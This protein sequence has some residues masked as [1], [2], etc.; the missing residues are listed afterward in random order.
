MISSTKKILVT[1]LLNPDLDGV[2]CALA[3]AEFLNKT[4]G[5][6]VAGIFGAPH[7][8]AQFVLDKFN[9]K[10]NH[11]TSLP[12]GYEDI[13]LVD[14]S[15]LEALPDLIKPERVIEIIDH[16]KTSQIEKFINAKI[17]IELVGAC[18]TLIAEKFKKNNLPISETAARL[19]YPAIFSNTDNFKGIVTKRDKNMVSWLDKQAN[20][21]PDFIHEMF[22]AKSKITKPIKDILIE[23]FKT[24]QFKNSRLGI[25]Q[26]EIINTDQYIK[27]NLPEIIKILPEIKKQKSLDYIFLNGLDLEGASNTFVAVDDIDI[28]LLESILNIK[29]NDHLATADRLIMRKEITPL[30]QAFL[31][32]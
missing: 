7:R 18:A 9:I 16:R 4:G 30:I 26:L 11:L 10:I 15:D 20:L 12:N 14:M 29:F 8:E 19:L 28:K 17:Q 25:A 5:D 31:E 6:A 1:T 27:N 22:L 32:N 23:D 3:Y 13:I 24:F 2:A 21:P